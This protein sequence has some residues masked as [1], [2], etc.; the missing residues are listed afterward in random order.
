[1]KNI[2]N[3]Y[4]HLCM[5]CAG[6]K[7]CTKCLKPIFPKVQ[8][9]G[10]KEEE[11]EDPV[12]SSKVDKKLLKEMEN[13]METLK[14]RS[15]RKIIRLISESKIDINKEKISWKGGKFIYKEDGKELE[16]MV[17]KKGS[18]ESNEGFED[19]DEEDEDFD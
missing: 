8:D 19:I 13:Y 5:I 1:M 10:E 11:K 16:G 3:A 15:R 6:K 12:D 7:T 18:M 9:E 17:Y 4:R 2:T 14:E